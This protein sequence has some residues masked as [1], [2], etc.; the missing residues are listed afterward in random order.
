M[1]ILAST[2][3]K[4][5]VGPIGTDGD[6]AFSRIDV[7][8]P[9]DA[10]SARSRLETVSSGPLGLA[11]PSGRVD[12][13]LKAFSDGTEVPDFEG[14][15]TGLTE[16]GIAPAGSTWQLGTAGFTGSERDVTVAEL[17]HR[18]IM[19]AGGAPNI[20]VSIQIGVDF[21]LGELSYYPLLT[22]GNIDGV[23]QPLLGHSPVE[24]S[25]TDYLTGFEEAKVEYSKPGGVGRH[26]GQMIRDI[27]LLAGIPTEKIG[28]DPEAGWGVELTTLY[29]IHCEPGVPA[30]KRIAESFGHFLAT[31]PA[32]TI[33]LRHMAPVD[34]P[35]VAVITLPLLETG[36]LSAELNVAP[37]RPKQCYLVTGARPQPPGE[38]GLVSETVMESETRALFSKPQ[39]Q[40]K[41][42]GVGAL[43]PTGLPEFLAPVNTVVSQTFVTTDTRE[44]CPVRK[45]TVRWM[46]K[47]PEINRYIT[48]PDPGTEDGTP[49]SYRQ[50]VFIFA[51]GAVI[52]DSSLGSL[53]H[54]PRFV[55]VE[56]TEELFFYDEIKHRPLSSDD[57]VGVP[58]AEGWRG[59]ELRV[60]TSRGAWA[61]HETTLKERDTL[62]E[63]WDTVPV[64]GGIPLRGNGEP[65]QDDGEIV[66]QATEALFVGPLAPDA[67]DGTY[68]P[69][70]G[71]PVLGTDI[72]NRGSWLST[73]EETRVAFSIES[74]DAHFTLAELN[75][76]RDVA[77]PGEFMGVSFDDN[78]LIDEQ[79]ARLELFNPPG[80]FNPL[81]ADHEIRIFPARPAGWLS[82]LVQV[83]K[84]WSRRPPPGAEAHFL[85][86]NNEQSDD[87]GLVGRLGET[88]AKDFVPQGDV[89]R[90]IET[91][92][93]GV[94]Q[95]LPSIN[96]VV[97]GFS[98][99]A[100]VCMP[101]IDS[102]ESIPVEGQCCDFANESF[103]P[104]VELIELDFGIEDAAF[105]KE[106]ACIW[107][108]HDSA[109]VATL[110]LANISAV[111]FSGA[112]MRLAAS[113]PPRGIDP[114]TYL[115]SNGVAH[116]SNGWVETVR[117]P[118]DENKRTILT[119]RLGV[120]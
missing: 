76:A 5:T 104:G 48:A 117:Y 40:F 66:A 75:S 1:I 120:V 14:T 54:E 34:E 8:D 53:W 11:A 98:P 9:P 112:P 32:G 31:S 68:P 25:G 77:K 16:V 4:I 52:D 21:G 102:L 83:D 116:L 81:T 10:A 23:R 105:A 99:I 3:S 107:R 42:N 62:G 74:P 55:P 65:I 46:W 44:G 85:W 88:R 97:T 73:T 90:E 27:L 70:T 82:G 92:T 58:R 43:A 18:T 57:P 87:D 30:A 96:R 17:W 91:N 79:I 69:F 26:A 94:G 37:T 72:P 93:D 59:R 113:G 56:I 38:G 2:R 61:L 115:D 109:P 60:I 86:S 49:R 41:Q 71:V 39:A 101:E 119:V 106:L 29:E 67:N 78:T 118:S 100:Q 35:P 103:I 15:L 19:G 13:W 36:E 64:R 24:L 111:F 89:H 114:E 45:L 7:A 47:V 28:I 51:V 84:S 110:G 12:S 63:A 108:R 33:V 6:E 50:D 80:P 95:P 20:A 22:D